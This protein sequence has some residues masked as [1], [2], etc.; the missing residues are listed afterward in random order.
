MSFSEDKIYELLGD[1]QDDDVQVV[2]DTIGILINI[3]KSISEE[4]VDT[5]DDS[6][7]LHVVIDLLNIGKDSFTDLPVL[8]ACNIRRMVL[9]A[10]LN[11]AAVAKL[12]RKLVEADLFEALVTLSERTVRIGH[13]HSWPD[14]V[15]VSVSLIVMLFS[16][17]INNAEKTIFF[18]KAVDSEV[19]RALLA[20]LIHP[21]PLD[22]A[23]ISM[24]CKV[25]AR[26][27]QYTNMDAAQ[28]YVALM[29]Q[30]GVKDPQKALSQIYQV[31]GAPA[32]AAV[33]TQTEGVKSSAPSCHHCGKE[34]AELLACGACKQV[35]YCQSSC[36]KADWKAHKP[37]C[38]TLRK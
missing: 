10:L 13:A 34:T 3:S 18:E 25:L 1:L 9:S 21:G 22:K 2:V 14:F 33:K 37:I 8:D 36:Q 7:L 11:F 15:E 5:I 19:H 35:F 17:I 38:K 26:W 20:L 23:R 32:D 27:C 4:D 16:L 12:Q 6:G 24:T 28:V 29:N 30:T 31:G